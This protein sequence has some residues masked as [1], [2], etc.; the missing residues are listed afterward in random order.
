MTTPVGQ[1]FAKQAGTDAAG[2]VPITRKKNEKRGAERRASV[3]KAAGGKAKAKAGP[4]LGPANNAPIIPDSPGPSAAAVKDKSIRREFLLD[5][6]HDP[7]S[8]PNLPPGFPIQPGIVAEHIK[9]AEQGIRKGPDGKTLVIGNPVQQPA[10]VAEL[11]A[12]IRDIQGVGPNPMKIIA[13]GGHEFPKNMKAFRLGKKRVVIAKNMLGMRKRKKTVILMGITTFWTL[14]SMGH[15]EVVAFDSPRWSCFVRL[16]GRRSPVTCHLDANKIIRGMC[17]FRCWTGF[18]QHEDY[19]PE[20]RDK[21]MKHLETLLNDNGV[22]DGMLDAAFQ[23]VLQDSREDSYIFDLRN[24]VFDRNDSEVFDVNMLIT[25]D[26]RGRDMEF[27]ML[28]ALSDDDE[29][30]KNDDTFD[31]DAY[32]TAISKA[33]LTT[34]RSRIPD[35]ADPSIDA[36]GEPTSAVG[37]EITVSLVPI[38]SDHDQRVSELT[39]P[40]ESVFE[41]DSSKNDTDGSRGLIL[42]DVEQV[43]QLGST[44]S[45]SKDSI[46]RAIE[47]TGSPT[48]DSGTVT[49]AANA[50]VSS[51]PAASAHRSKDDEELHAEV[52]QQISDALGLAPTP[53]TS[54]RVGGSSA[55]DQG[56]FLRTPTT[57]TMAPPGGRATPSAHL[58]GA[59]SQDWSETHPSGPKRF[60]TLAPPCRTTLGALHSSGPYHSGTAQSRPYPTP[61][62]SSSHE[63]EVCGLLHHSSG[64]L[65]SMAANADPAVASTSVVSAGRDATPPLERISTPQANPRHRHGTIGPQRVVPQQHSVVSLPQPELPVS[66][67]EHH[68]IADGTDST[69]P[70]A[71]LQGDGTKTFVEYNVPGCP[72]TIQTTKEQ[73]RKLL[74]DYTRDK[75][76]LCKAPSKPGPSG[77]FDADVA[78]DNWLEPYKQLLI[79]LHLPTEQNPIEHFVAMRVSQAAYVCP[80]KIENN[81]R[82]TSVCGGKP[83]EFELEANIFLYQYFHVRTPA[84]FVKF[85]AEKFGLRPSENVVRSLKHITRAKEGF[86]QEDVAKHNT[87]LQTHESFKTDLLDMMLDNNPSFEYDLG[88]GRLKIREFARQNLFDEGVDEFIRENADLICEFAPSFQNVVPLNELGKLEGALTGAASVY[89]SS[90]GTVFGPGARAP[91][92]IQ[93]G[94]YKVGDPCLNP[95]ITV[96]PLNTCS[97]DSVSSAVA[98]GKSSSSAAVASRSAP[99]TPNR[100]NKDTGGSSSSKNSGETRAGWGQPSPPRS[101]AEWGSRRA[102]EQDWN[103][104][105]NGGYNGGHYKDTA[106]GNS[107][108]YSSKKSWGNKSEWAGD[109]SNWRDGGWHGDNNSGWNNKQWKGTPKKENGSPKSPI[110]PD[111][112][113][114]PD[115]FKTD[116]P[117]ASNAGA[118]APQVGF[119]RAG[120]PIPQRGEKSSEPGGEKTFTDFNPDGLSAFVEVDMDEERK[121]CEAEIMAEL[122][123]EAAQHAAEH[124]SR[125]AQFSRSDPTPTGIST[126]LK[127][128]SAAAVVAFAGA[129]GDVEPDPHP[130]RYSSESMRFSAHSCFPGADVPSESRDNSLAET[131]YSFGVPAN[132]PALFGPP[133]VV[134]MNAPFSERNVLTES[135]DTGAD[136][137]VH[138]ALGLKGPIVADASL[139]HSFTIENEFPIVLLEKDQ[140]VNWRGINHGGIRKKVL[141]EGNGTRPTAGS[142]VTIDIRAFAIPKTW[143]GDSMSGRKTMFLDHHNVRKTIRVNHEN[144]VP[145]DTWS[146]SLLS[147]DYGETCEIACHS[148]HLAGIEIPNNVVLS[149]IELTLVE[150]SLKANSDS[151]LSPSAAMKQTFVLDEWPT[152]DPDERNRHGDFMGELVSSSSENQNAPF[153]GT[154]T[155][156]GVISVQE[157][158]RPKTGSGIPPLVAEL[159]ARDAY[160]E[161]MAD[162]L[163]GSKLVHKTAV[164]PIS[165]FVAGSENLLADGISRLENPSEKAYLS[166]GQGSFRE[167]GAPDSVRKVGFSVHP[168][169]SSGAPVRPVDPDLVPSSRVF[170]GS[171]YNTR[172]SFLNTVRGVSASTCPVTVFGG[173]GGSASG[174]GVPARESSN[175]AD[176]L[177]TFNT[178]APRQRGRS[179]SGDSD[180]NDDDDP[181]RER[182]PG[183]GTS[184]CWDDNAQCPRCP[185]LLDALHKS[186][187]LCAKHQKEHD[188]EIQSVRRSAQKELDKVQKA[189]GSTENALQKAST[190]EAENKREIETAKR[191]KW[192]VEKSLHAA[193]K[194]LKNV[195]DLLGAVRT[196]ATTLED[197]LS[198]AKVDLA[199]KEH[200][201]ATALE[202]NQR[203][204]THFSDLENEIHQLRE[205]SEQLTKKNN[206]IFQKVHAAELKNAKAAAEIEEEKARSR[207]LE[208]ELAKKKNAE[209][210]LFRC[211]DELVQKEKDN[212]LLQDQVEMTLRFKER[213]LVKYSSVN[214]LHNSLRTQLIAY[215]DFHKAVA[216]SLNTRDIQLFRNLVEDLNTKIPVPI[217]IPDDISDLGSFAG[218]LEEQE[219]M[220]ARLKISETL[221]ETLNSRVSHAHHLLEKADK[222]LQESLLHLRSREEDFA[223][224]LARKKTE[225][226]GEV[227]YNENMK[228]TLQKNIDRL[229]VGLDD[230]NKKLQEKTK[231]LQDSYS[232]LAQKNLVMQTAISSAAA[233]AVAGIKENSVSKDY[234]ASQVASLQAR[235]DSAETD[236]QNHEHLRSES[237]RRLDEVNRLRNELA[238][239]T[240]RSTEADRE[241]QTKLSEAT[242][243]TEEFR[244]LYDAKMAE[245]DLLRRDMNENYTVKGAEA[246]AGYPQSAPFET[247]RDHNSQHAQQNNSQRNPTPS[248]YYGQG[249]SSSSSR[250][251][252]GQYEQNSSSAN[253]SCGTQYRHHDKS[254]QGPVLF[255][256]A[257]TE[258]QEP[259]STTAHGQPRRGDTSSRRTR[260]GAGGGGPGGDPEDDDNDND[261][262]RNNDRKDGRRGDDRRG[263]RRGSG[264]RGSDD[265]PLGGPSRP[266]SSSSGQVVIGAPVISTKDVAALD[267]VGLVLPSRR[268]RHAQHASILQMNG[269]P[270]Q[271]G[272]V[273]EHDLVKG[274]EQELCAAYG[275]K[276]WGAG[277]LQESLLMHVNELKFHGKDPKDQSRYGYSKSDR[278]SNWYSP[279]Q[280]EITAKLHE[281]NGKEKNFSEGAQS[282]LRSW[283]LQCM[284]H[285]IHR[286]FTPARDVDQNELAH[287]FLDS[288]FKFMNVSENITQNNCTLKNLIFNTPKKLRYDWSDFVDFI[289]MLEP[290][291]ST[292]N[293]KDCEQKVLEAIAKI[294]E[295]S[296]FASKL[297][298]Q[299]PTQR[300]FNNHIAPNIKGFEDA[301]TRLVTLRIVASSECLPD[302]QYLNNLIISVLHPVSQLF[303]ISHIPSEAEF[304]TEFINNCGSPQQDASTI[305]INGTTSNNLLLLLVCRVVWFC[306]HLQN[307]GVTFIKTC[308]RGLLKV[309]STDHLKLQLNVLKPSDLRANHLAG[310]AHM[311]P[312]GAGRDGGNRGNVGRGGGG[313]HWS[314]DDT[315]RGRGGAFHNMGNDDDGYHLYSNEYDLSDLGPISEYSD[316]Q[317]FWDQHNVYYWPGNENPH[318]QPHKNPNGITYN[319]I[320]GMGQLCRMDFENPNNEWPQPGRKPVD[321]ELREN[322]LKEITALNIDISTENVFL[323][324]LRINKAEFIKT[325]SI[326]CKSGTKYVAI[327]TKSK[328]DPA[329]PKNGD[330]EEILFW[331][332]HSVPECILYSETEGGGNMVEHSCPSGGACWLSHTRKGPMVAGKPSQDQ[333]FTTQCNQLLGGKRALYIRLANKELDRM[334]ENKDRR[335]APL[336]GLTPT[337]RIKHE[338][339]DGWWTY[340]HPTTVLTKLPVSQAAIKNDREVDEHLYNLQ[341]KFPATIQMQGKGKGKGKGKDNEGGPKGG[342]PNGGGEAGF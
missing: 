194:D 281:M 50:P 310:F 288:L 256:P 247:C 102:A 109:S 191:D 156:G 311:G 149:S 145:M 122:E 99:S 146:R 305:P 259:D 77:V 34:S 174:C 200:R 189:L 245:I 168:S 2:D 209:R 148:S 197:N 46:P 271:I 138:L 100:D 105:N 166:S 299:V 17:Y 41:R 318:H 251:W 234:H 246:A 314:W 232:E 307:S 268:T 272:P 186:E 118:A 214:K 220:A 104:R 98:A 96:Q 302:M 282:D 162:L 182:P 123:R 241:H 49:G 32:G 298:S 187:A 202:E 226:E 196:R 28:E 193:T 57:E 159:R 107:G 297:G 114:V 260:T 143:S 5:P 83:D 86:E 207:Q 94:S 192:N 170:V 20:I 219:S 225:F 177:H 211:K 137:S 103:Y 76:Y 30:C 80:S 240:R 60:C 267:M 306:R 334:I 280:K 82:M 250:Y 165:K 255:N 68:S 44:D 91:Q 188:A 154:T 93:D 92:N 101:S 176:P 81:G 184:D 215:S 269:K 85:M 263:G 151:N 341:I 303:T 205:K 25:G 171:T 180:G 133:P 295:F 26:F 244:R 18:P 95:P 135:M 1:L 324:Q 294:V 14:A 195:E 130:D 108:G 175:A 55:E 254:S 39:S 150:I 221:V 337:E 155:S 69:T 142:V 275:P 316:V 181:G 217:G 236:L 227:Q 121:K 45:A 42:V 270:G 43:V 23:A 243:E 325:D 19:D 289:N 15:I 274:L 249:Q 65:D 61:R 333:E 24:T 300:S 125:G 12:R 58:T 74:E 169:T 231:K 248:P 287:Q 252:N 313:Q 321:K 210:E 10:N 340:E 164:V 285:E 198:S 35:G 63:S 230:T 322:A 111:P 235:L 54:S 190:K 113:Y 37:H 78:W 342:G 262:N 330:K 67:P 284:Q 97:I 88:N 124:S 21:V 183:L 29:F 273:N 139:P 258:E 339:Q 147:M 167:L 312:D 185:V 326:I 8:G 163:S 132:G 6:D 238:A 201:L 212:K 204:V 38:P 222:K 276:E 152:S 11:A 40:D 332:K 53:A 253:A 144:L 237:T 304:V 9:L 336:Q 112:C 218:D 203:Y 213:A 301:V 233:K 157:P 179:T 264:G 199:A 66:N 79:D 239:T 116:S 292:L 331:F 131:A 90:A 172:E 4:G 328:K 224:E 22:T 327:T 72:Q 178:R 257:E 64:E 106:Y 290:S 52:C 153:R 89:Y 27:K 173:A 291:E 323:A 206:E 319:H 13:P 120:T 117:V 320:T 48:P 242:R 278:S 266:R 110:N 59:V 261:P 127:T 134:G 265:D 3:G 279:D 158:A 329:N 140:D 317:E 75:L 141:V 70:A 229:N 161:K 73:E 47:T 293:Q 7:S 115:C 283:L 87:A 277:I 335:V 223:K 216:A 71:P 296:D 286:C 208:T 33:K 31:M 308:L 126:E 160:E 16:P 51:A 84:D 62:M 309:S 129:D 315:Y 228:E 56:S 119:R 128:R 136:L 338:Q 36:S